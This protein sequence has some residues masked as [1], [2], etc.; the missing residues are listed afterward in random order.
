M[1]RKLFILAIV[2]IA[3]NYF[4]GD[5]ID[6]WWQGWR[7][8]EKVQEIGQDLANQA[9]DQITGQAIDQITD[10]IGNTSIGDI[11]NLSDNL[12]K[13]I[14]LQIDNWLL[15]QSLNEYG[16]PEGT[17]YTGGTPTFNEATGEITDRFQL[18]FGKFPD[19]LDKF[20][21]SIEELKETVDEAAQ[22]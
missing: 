19:L 1:I 2:L 13:D 16:D 6:N 17:N 11:E 12:P 22:E 18:I 4:F 7:S 10:N 3:V 20:K 14:Q 15:S 9:I 5:Q 21:I 8:G